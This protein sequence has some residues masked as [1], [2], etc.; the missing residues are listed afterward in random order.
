MPVNTHRSDF[1]NIRMCQRCFVVRSA[2]FE[3]RRTSVCVADNLKCRTVQGY[4]RLDRMRNDDL[5]TT[6]ES[7]EVLTAAHHYKTN[8]WDRLTCIF[9]AIISRNIMEY[10]QNEKRMGCRRFEDEVLNR[11]QRQ[12]TTTSF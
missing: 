3:D 2:G 6:L 10:A 8:L 11:Q 9:T 5:R 4:S 1:I 12:M 7:G